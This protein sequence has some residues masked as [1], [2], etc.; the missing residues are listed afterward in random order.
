ME[1]LVG[2]LRELSDEQRAE[3]LRPLVENGWTGNSGAVAPLQIS[4][5]SQR[6][7]GLSA[8][9]LPR[10][11]R[12]ADLTV[13]LMDVLSRLDQT[14]L[15]TL[16]ALSPRS[17][18]LKRNESVRRAAGRFLLGEVDTIEPQLRECAGLVGALLAATLGGGRIY[19]QQYLERFAPLAIEDVVK[20]EGGG[21]MF[22]RS[23]KERCWERYID[24]ARD[25]ST[26]DLIERK[27][28]ECLAAVVQRTAEKAGVGI[29]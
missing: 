23:T 27:V 14:S 21:G 24:L 12:L 20:A 15:R 4:E 6:A 9:Q 28:R 13:M 1:R 25:M 17:S 8:E 11:D 2:I 3:L 29:R 18:L 19:G 16:E 5:E 7:L 10:W 26:P 22:G